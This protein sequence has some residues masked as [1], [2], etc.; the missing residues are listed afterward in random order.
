MSGEQARR[1]VTAGRGLTGRDQVELPLETVRVAGGLF[2]YR[3][4]YTE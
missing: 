3:N 1:K 2:P 4:G